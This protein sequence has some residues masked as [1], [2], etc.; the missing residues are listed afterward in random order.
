VA[1]HSS[2]VLG[3]P[4]GVGTSF[5]QAGAT[6]STLATTSAGATAGGH[7]LVVTPGSVLSQRFSIG[8][9]DQLDLTKLLAGAPLAADL[10][11]IG[12]FVKVLG[13]GRNDPGFGHGTRTT[14]EITGPGGRAIVNLEGSGKLDVKDLLSHDSLILPP[15]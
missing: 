14:L 4:G 3:Q 5:L 15:H 13:Y 7:D 1:I 10:T 8:H 2:N 12:D 6:G 11:N 9:G